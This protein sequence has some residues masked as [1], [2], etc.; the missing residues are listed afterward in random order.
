MTLRYASLG[1]GSSGNA[2]VIEARCAQHTTRLLLDCG[3]SVRET[4]RR[5]ARLDLTGSD[6]DAIV[7]THEHDDHIGGVAKF[8]R[9]FGTPLYM[10]RGTFLSVAQHSHSCT[11]L[12]VQFCHDS[13][14][15]W[16]QNL[17]IRPYTV[18]H[19]AREPLQ[20]TFHCQNI[21]LGVL[22]D[23]GHI[24]PNVV[25]AL[26]GSHG[27]VLEYNYDAHMMAKSTKYPPSLKSRIT[28]NYGHLD[29]TV[30]QQLLLQLIHP[31]LHHVHAAHISGNNNDSALVEQLL[32]RALSPSQTPYTVACQDDG[33]DWFSVSATH[34][35]S[36]PVTSMKLV[37]A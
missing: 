34:A 1:S 2:L 3:F 28:G 11:Q 17:E 22:T 7:V 15:F 23:I 5:L 35:T 21:Q 36:A 13:Q 27:L 12:N 33:F 4:E 30:A 9:K 8:A 10:S 19:D 31:Q 37:S 32:H 14:P 29:N 20:F 18:P 25:Q 26:R 6:I 24:T 16:I